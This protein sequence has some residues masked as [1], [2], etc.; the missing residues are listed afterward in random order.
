MITAYSIEEMRDFVRETKKKRKTIGFV[1][2]MG[3]LHEGHLSLIRKA[4]E[5]CDTVIISIYVNPIQFDNSNDLAAYPRTVSADLQAA[6]DAGVACVFLPD[7]E[8]MYI[9]HKTSVQVKHLTDALC[10]AARPGHFTGV[11][12]VV[13]K[14]FHIVQPDYAYFGQKDIQQARSIEKMVF[15]LNMPVTIVL[16]PIVREPGGLALSSRNVHLDADQKKRALSLYNALQYADTC[17]QSGMRNADELISAMR[18]RIDAEGRPDAV[19]YISIVDYEE[20]QPV[21]TV[22]GQCV[23]ALAAYFGS[24]R[25]IDNTIVVA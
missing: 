6:A 8:T 23:I 5:H 9:N 25:L 14:L 19:D 1:P 7:D 13:T 17:I 4:A 24:T 18:T 10:G 2:T 3:A 12:T 16:A 11:F 20:L 15:D 21:E 22:R